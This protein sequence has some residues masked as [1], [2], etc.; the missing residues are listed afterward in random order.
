MNTRPL[1]PWTVALL[2]ALAHPGACPSAPAQA[3]TNTPLVAITA[4]FDPRSAVFQ[5]A[6]GKVVAVDG[7]PGIEITTEPDKNW[8]G[9]CFNA[10]DDDFWDLSASQG[11]E[12]VIKN[13]SA[14]PLTF[15]ARVDNPGDWRANKWNGHNTRVPPGET[16]AC[17]VFFGQSW[18][19]PGY[20]LDASMVS[21]FSVFTGKGPG[22]RT[23][24]LLGVRPFGTAAARPAPAPRKAYRS[25]PPDSPAKL[26]MLS[27]DDRFDFGS[28][29]NNGGTFARSPVPGA[30]RLT[31]PANGNWPGV[32]IP[33]PGGKWDLSNYEYI[34]LDVH[35]V[36]T[37]DVDVNIRV[38]NPGSAWPKNCITHRAVV[39]PDERATLTVPIKRAGGGNIK[40]FGMVGYP[41]GMYPDGAALDPENVVA[42]CVYTL[43]GLPYECRID[44]SNVYAAG[45]FV[46]PTWLELTAREFFPILDRYGQFRHKDWPGKVHGDAD[47][48][49]AR[50]AEQAALAKDPGPAGWDKFGGWAGGP[51]LDATG[52]FRVAKHNGRWWFVDPEGRLFFSTG[53]TGV[54]YGWGATPI[55]DRRRW[56]EPL[57][58]NEGPTAVF[59]RKSYR[60]WSGYYSGRE[61]LMF[62][63]SSQN[64]QWKYGDHWKETYPGLV[65][66]RLRAWGLNTIANWSGPDFT[67]GQASDPRTPYTGTIFYGSKKLSN[68]GSGFPDPFD[69]SF[70]SGLSTATRQWTRQSANDPWCIGYFLD[71]ELP[72]GGETT[73]AEDA[74]KAAPDS[75]AKKELVRWLGGRYPT[76]ADLNAAWG[77]NQ[78]SWEALLNDQPKSTAPRT[79]A[80]RKDLSEF[81][82]RVAEAYFKHVRE[83][84]KAAAPNKL[85]LGCRCV[86]GSDQV[87]AVAVRYCDVFSYNRYVYSL[88]DQKLPLNLDGPMLVGEFHFGASDRGLF[89]TGLTSA[90]DQTDRGRKY[91]TYVNSALDNPQLVGTHWFQYGDEPAT[92]RGDGENGQ[93]GFVDI[94]DTPYAETIQASRA[95]AD[96]MYARRAAA[97]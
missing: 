11:L 83:A 41:Q 63:F 53:V 69:P 8:P 20:D 82:V 62:D 72:W 56:F 85:Y 24:V 51:Q 9:I 64:L 45:R 66:Q 16:K 55:E 70:A 59:Y 89:Y 79:E 34:S 58:P 46:A 52:H 28:P 31:F 57:P 81:T 93:L 12:F 25:A 47:L 49:K 10:R 91:S 32:I 21:A 44:V 50:Q 60:L 23:F 87:V 6:T 43:K 96:A 84:I 92:G 97:K 38:D 35:N 71:N 2:A 17:P 7:Q 22:A 67:F 95:T 73:L 42:I 74:L 27:F 54:T 40:L 1:L 94:C 14:E 18:G 33:S 75:A 37:K 88:W 68:R 4:N 29:K 90:D 30:L 61:P 80:A 65:H 48:A 13:T 5:A 26:Q 76:I 86:G 3:S 77:A 19:G 39:Q 78:T 36:D 15:T